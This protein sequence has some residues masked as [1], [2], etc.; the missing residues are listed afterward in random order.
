MSAPHTRCRALCLLALC[1]L[2][3]RAARAQTGELDDRLVALTYHKVTGQPLDVDA[4][5]ARTDA[6]RSATNFDRPD[7]IKAEAARLAS[8]LAAVDPKHEFV[9][10]VG[11]NVS[12]YD[13]ARGTFTIP[14]FTPGFYVI[15][16]AF[17]EE[18]RI[19]FDNGQAASTIP[20]P[21][22]E[23][24]TFDARLRQQGRN[25]LD[26]I[27]FR[28][29]GDGDP[30]GA[31]TGRHV[32]RA[33]IVSARVLDREGT[34]L[35]TPSL[36]ATS[37]AVAGAGATPPFDIARADVAGLRVGGKAKDL[38][39]TLGRLFGKVTRVPRG[40]G[41]YPGYAASLEVN[42]MGCLTIPGRR[43]SGE[44]G[45]VCVTAYL[46]GDD[47]V[48]AVRIER[49]FPFIDQEAFRATLVRRYGA[50]TAADSRGGYALG[51]GPE[52][53]GALAYDRG[54]P[55][56]ALTAHYAEEEDM[57]SRSLNAAP[58][59]R[60]TL[61]LVDAQWASAKH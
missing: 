44:E 43:H 31:V 13:H 49:V 15:A 11:D 39:T 5:A 41:W 33:T 53:D 10:R 54:G 24:R 22:E 14:L 28:V 61:Q 21:K 36:T 25:V 8:E 3:P 16:N 9:V 34:V 59:I 19:A 60:V 4:A 38:E 7:V 47:V 30:A 1:F 40:N 48:R 26:E 35:F 18:Y 2:A 42:S 20:M 17:G 58:N 57:M 56:S 51:W 55:H 52:L 12:E 29:V 37:G 6:A 32:V 27:H 45:N 23:A 46:D 50:V